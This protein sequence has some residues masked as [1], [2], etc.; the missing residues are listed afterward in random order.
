MISFTGLHSNA[1][2]FEMGNMGKYFVMNT[3]LTIV[4]YGQI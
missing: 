4:Y 3:Y 1:L 2:N